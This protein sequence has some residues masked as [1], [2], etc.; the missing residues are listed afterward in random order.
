MDFYNDFF[1]WWYVLVILILYIPLLVTVYFVFI[2]MSAS[3][4]EKITAV[5]DLPCACWLAILS[6]CLAEWWL[7]IY[8]IWIYKPKDVYTGYQTVED[9]PNG[10]IK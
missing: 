7:I 3:K 6:L 5:N 2:W 1:D 10:Y 9:N 8:I 4:E